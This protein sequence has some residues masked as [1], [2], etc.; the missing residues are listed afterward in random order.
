MSTH[1][2]YSIS[3]GSY[4]QT[5]YLERGGPQD[6]D[7]GVR[8]ARWVLRYRLQKR[9]LHQLD[10]FSCNGRFVKANYAPSRCDA[11]LRLGLVALPFP[12]RASDDKI[13]GRYSIWR[14]VHSR[15]G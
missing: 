11:R 6:Q 13:G 8:H 14:E 12:S 9:P 10:D 2:V 15:H 1:A 7:A 3:R 4:R 5:L